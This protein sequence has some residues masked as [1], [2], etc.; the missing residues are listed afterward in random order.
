MNNITL[1]RETDIF[2]LNTVI[3]FLLLFLLL[4]YFYFIFFY[5]TIFLL[6]S[7][8][9]APVVTCMCVANILLQILHYNFVIAYK[10]RKHHSIRS[11]VA[12]FWSVR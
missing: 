5:P 2:L 6:F 1:K 11:T 9:F 4:L 7:L 8:L 12:H 3:S 10:H